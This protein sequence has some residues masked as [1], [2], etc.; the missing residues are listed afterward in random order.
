MSAIDKTFGSRR[1]D[2]I[3]VAGTLPLLAAAGALHA[4]QK[5]PL[6]KIVCTFAPGGTT[7]LL[8]RK[9][10]L[11]MPA[12]YAGSVIVENKAGA[13]GQVGV[14][15]VRTLPTDGSVILQ[16]A[17]TMFT[18]S[19]HVQKDPLPYDPVADFIPLTAGCCMDYAYAVGPMVPA[20]VRTV[21]EYLAWVRRD[22][23][24]A[25]VATAG[26]VSLIVGAVLG[27]AAGIDLVNVSYKGGALAVQDTIAGNVPALVT[28]LGDVLPHLGEGR[29]RLIAVTSDK[30]SPFV[31]NVATFAE[32]GV[33]DMVHRVYFSFFAH[34][35]MPAEVIAAHSAALRASLKQ[36]DVVDSLGRATMEVVATDLKETSE[37]FSRDRA[38]WAALIAKVGYK[39][40]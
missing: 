9:V 31:P 16:T 38:K 12:G 39:P 30:R 27:K 7:D 11:N 26:V 10:A 6:L 21:P 35:K 20:S 40:T 34:A 3:A 17:M 36:Q 33:A 19:Q 29:L 8:S 13:A 14:S 1:R 5:F 37:L 25:T 23:K 32:Q 2:I 4:Q 28:T 18:L 24:H 22:A 15:Y